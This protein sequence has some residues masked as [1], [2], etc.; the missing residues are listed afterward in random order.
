M[1]VNNQLVGGVDF[2][3]SEK[4]GFVSWDDPPISQ[5]GDSCYSKGLTSVSN[6]ENT[7]QDELEGYAVFMDIEKPLNWNHPLERTARQKK[8]KNCEYNQKKGKTVS[9]TIPKGTTIFHREV[10]LTC[11]CPAG[12]LVLTSSTCRGWSVVIFPAKIRGRS[13][14]VI[15]TL[16]FPLVMTNSSPWKDPH[17]FQFGKP[18]YY[19]NGPSKSHGYVK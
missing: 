5:I 7:S 13:D 9:I 2:N 12:Q 18:S 15:N 1:M 4:Y 11:Q 10:D 3:P 8:R 16:W 6:I 17:I 14:F 19:I